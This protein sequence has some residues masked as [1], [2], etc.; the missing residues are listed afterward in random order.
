MEDAAGGVWEARDIEVDDMAI[1]LNYPI[2]PPPAR[3]L[4]ACCICDPLGACLDD[5]EFQ[6]CAGTWFVGQACTELTCPQDRP[7]N[8][9][10]AD[11]ITVTDGQHAFNNFCATLE[12]DPPT[13][14]I[15]D[16][17]EEPNVCDET[18]IGADIW[19]AYT[20]SCSGRL[21]ISMCDQAN[22]DAVL[23]VYTNGTDTCECP[24]DDTLLTA[25]NDDACGAF[26]APS[27]VE[28]IAT[29]GVCY[30]IRIGGW[31][32]YRC[33]P[34]DPDYD[35]DACREDCKDGCQGQGFFDVLCE[36]LTCFPPDALAED[37]SCPTEGCEFGGC[38]TK[39][40][41]ASFSTDSAEIQAVR[42]TFISVPGFEF[43]EGRTMWV[44]EPVETT[45]ASGSDGP[46][47]VGEA[48]MWAANLGC[49]P[50]YT[51]WSQYDVVDI[52]DGALVGDGVYDIQ[53]ILDGDLTAVEEC[54]S[55]ALTV[56][57]SRLGDAVGSRTSPQPASPPNCDCNFDDIGQIVEKFKNEPA[58]PRKARADII[59]SNT[60]LPKPDKKIDF[61]DISCAVECFRGTP[62]APAGPPLVD[63]C[64][65]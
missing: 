2:E 55:P 30:T 8:D 1:C 9:D 27:E 45:E 40:R 14:P 36:D 47:G 51:N 5:V 13:D 4:G 23:G 7:D 54:Y 16:G 42:V 58:S 33:D 39:S 37:P 53:A 19:F 38:G 63:P 18:D 64:G 57:L 29:E 52:L 46:P 17:G 24:T 56:N 50:F 49:T 25:C 62:C 60:T 21:L 3:A 6:D 43:A 22:Y 32:D 28:F 26:F 65:P 11:I 44:Q 61:V 35:P 48:S 31:R 10:C 59:N 34:L 12:G 41:Y 20:A 15:M